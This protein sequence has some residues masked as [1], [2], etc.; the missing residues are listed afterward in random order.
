MPRMCCHL[1]GSC[2][3]IDQGGQE[4]SR[5]PP[6]LVECGRRGMRTH[7]DRRR[8]RHC[9]WVGKQGE[10]G[11]EGEEEEEEPP[12]DGIRPH[13]NRIRIINIVIGLTGATRCRCS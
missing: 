1:Y 4:D 2:S 6:Q 10:E 7:D 9:R 12:R 3:M 5:Q 13:P 11:M 8:R